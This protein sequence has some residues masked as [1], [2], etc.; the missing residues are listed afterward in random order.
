MLSRWA[1]WVADWTGCLVHCQACAHQPAA[2]LKQ[3]NRLGSAVKDVHTPLLRPAFPLYA[4]ALAIT[5]L[6]LLAMR[7]AC[8]YLCGIHNPD[9]TCLSLTGALPILMSPARSSCIALKGVCTRQR[10][11][12]GLGCPARAAF[13]LQ[14]HMQIVS[15]VMPGL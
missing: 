11:L 6:A 1:W 7:R 13:E 10:A 12:H 9:S 2:V 8:I 15:T 14:S 3:L 4:P 5:A